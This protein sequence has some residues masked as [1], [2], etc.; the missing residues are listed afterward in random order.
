MGEQG[1]GET[2]VLGTAYEEVMGDLRERVGRAEGWTAVE[3]LSD[4]LGFMEREASIL[5]FV[6]EDVL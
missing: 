6:C 1:D 4:S 3:M 2:G 5:M